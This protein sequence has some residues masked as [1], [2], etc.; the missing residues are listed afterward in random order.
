M[1][2][3]VLTLDI[4]VVCVLICSQTFIDNF[5]GF[6]GGESI[7]KNKGTSLP[8]SGT[9]GHTHT[10][11]Y[12]S[13]SV[14]NYILTQLSLK[15]TQ[16]QP[17]S[18]CYFHL[19]F[20]MYLVAISN[21]IFCS[22]ICL[23]VYDCSMHLKMLAA[24]CGVSHS[25]WSHFKSFAMSLSMLQG[26]CHIFLCFCSWCLNTG[27]IIWMS[28]GPAFSQ[29]DKCPFQEADNLWSICTWQP[30]VSGAH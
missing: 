6:C 10:H 12:I 22:L 9:I 17:Q 19:T 30:P 11:I 4:L 28:C 26:F 5:S 14:H 23:F 13:H 29:M 7:N 1:A 24:A 16:L 3:L 27:T 20:S 8:T 18:Q 25:M 2:Y 15:G 21:F